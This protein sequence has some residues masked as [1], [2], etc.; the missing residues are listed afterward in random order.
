LHEKKAGNPRQEAEIP[1]RKD[2]RTAQEG[3]AAAQKRE[4]AG[5]KRGEAELKVANAELKTGS[6]GLKTREYEA[7][8]LARPPRPP[9]SRQD[10]KR[11]GDFR[12]ALAVWSPE[13][14]A[15]IP[16]LIVQPR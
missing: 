16:V 13:R 3:K 10:K 5:Q 14:C 4:E 11:P 2:K 7:E 8:K 15:R 1:A 12:P 9:P 6:A